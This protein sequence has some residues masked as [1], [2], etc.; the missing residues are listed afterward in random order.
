MRTWQV[1]PHPLRHPELH[2]DVSFFSSFGMQVGRLGSPGCKLNCPVASNSIHRINATPL[3]RPYPTRP[4]EACSATRRFDE[5]HNPSLVPVR[6]HR[7]SS[8][9]ASSAAVARG[10]ASIEKLKPHKLLLTL[11]Q[12]RPPRCRP[13]F[14]APP[15]LE[16]PD[17]FCTG[18]NIA[19]WRPHLCVYGT[20]RPSSGGFS[21]LELF[22][23]I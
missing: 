14:S 8:L 2:R 4:P 5:L 15:L 22:V 7:A 10:P 21:P 1:A 6:R 13:L 12:R 19:L 3:C 11:H 20:H 9:R 17:A 18:P 23:E 16:H